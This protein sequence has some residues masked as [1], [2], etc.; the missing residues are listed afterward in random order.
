MVRPWVM[1]YPA[2][3]F[4]VW[5]ARSFST[6]LPYSPVDVVLVSEKSDKGIGRVAV[7]FLWESGGGSGGSDDYKEWRS[8]SF[9]L[10]FE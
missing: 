10:H 2:V 4:G 7:G 9:A 6:E 3:H 1:P 5:V 8:A